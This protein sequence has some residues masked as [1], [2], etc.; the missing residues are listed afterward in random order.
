[1]KD[2]FERGSVLLALSDHMVLVGHRLDDGTN[3][4]SELPGDL[5]AAMSEDNLI[6]ARDG[7]MR[8]HQDGRI[9]APLPHGHKQFLKSL[10][11]IVDAVR[12]EGA[13]D[14]FRVEFD[15]AAFGEFF[16]GTA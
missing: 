13:V 1:M 16:E 9:L 3:L 6:A 5:D 12:Y 2:R 4:S 11:V 10:V 8:P 7:G 14:E 15:D